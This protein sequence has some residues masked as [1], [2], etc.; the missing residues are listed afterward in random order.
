MML[1]GVTG[2]GAILSVGEL[3]GIEL[4]GIELSGIELSG[5]MGPG[6]KTA[7]PAERVA[8]RGWRW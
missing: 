1:S 8:L 7:S 4:S 3:S 6:A 2:L 5:I